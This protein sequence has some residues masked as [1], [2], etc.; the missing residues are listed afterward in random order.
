MD[1]EIDGNCG[2]TDRK[3]RSIRLNRNKIPIS[4]R[5]KKILHRNAN[6][7]RTSFPILEAFATSSCETISILQTE[8]VS[9]FSKMFVPHFDEVSEQISPL[10]PYL[11]ETRRLNWI[12]V[13]R[14]EL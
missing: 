2:K 7:V 13:K 3:L 14:I 4:L 9:R 11:L 8:L 10:C 5:L 1:R 6:F 12:S